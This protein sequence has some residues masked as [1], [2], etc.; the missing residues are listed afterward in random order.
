[1]TNQEKFRK[2]INQMKAYRYALTIIGWDSNTEAPRNAF[3]RRAK[4]TGY[5]SKELFLLQTA[6]DYQEIVNH[7]YEQRE[8]L[9][10]L[11]Q[12]EVKKAKKDIDKII[13][14]PEKEF[15]AY[16]KLITESQL[17]WEDAKAND[18]FD[19]FKSNLYKIIHYNKKFA[20]Y[21]DNDAN[22]YDTLL[23]DYEEGM[24][25]KEYDHFF[26]TLKR[27][28][29]PFVK[30]T[31]KKSDK[32]Y[33]SLRNDHFPTEKQKEFSQYLLDQ[34]SFDRK[35][36]LIKESVHPFTWNTSPEDVRLTTKYMENYIFSSIYSTIH[37]L[38]HATYEQQISTDLDDTLLN[39]GT[40]MGIHESQSRFYENNIGRSLAFWET[41]FDQFESLFPEQT[42]NFTAA[43]MYKAANHVEASLIR[44]EADEL[45]Y[46]IHIMLRYDIERML[47]NNDINVD[48][49]PKV[50]NDLVEKYL[51]VRPKNDS[52]GVLQD[53]H[54]SGGMLGYFPTYA[55]GSAYS[56]QIYYAMKKEIDIEKLIRDK[57]ISKIN[58]WLKDKIHQ[59][60]SAKTPKELMK[61]VSGEAFN[62]KYYV[63]YLKDKFTK[64]YN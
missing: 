18:D 24:T 9:D 14:I 19:S 49:L 11:L 55:L 48:D 61:L 47:F 37:E 62:P 52:E 41:H 34:F 46:P 17:I 20:L 27:D 3:K 35:S 5:L 21:Y 64:I 13:H 1:M 43:D 16:Q 38:G 6:S 7:L 31:L 12:R 39:G 32:R 30:Q 8:D 51:G 29:V 60:G 2:K 26:E 40:S 45:T 4:M 23:Q 63:Q 36:G 53:V 44:I 22:P 33:N 57:E 25:T 10:D 54:W 59:Y 50:W 42:K 58:D 15:I 28:L 56:A